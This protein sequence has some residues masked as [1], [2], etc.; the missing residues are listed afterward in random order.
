MSD[1]VSKLYA[2]IGFKV[3]QDGLKQAQTLLKELAKQMSDINN[4]TKS[5]AREFGIFS[6]SQN[7]QALNDAKLAT[8]NEKAENQRHKR[9][10][11]SKKF[12]HKQLM[13][14][15]KLEF[16]VEKYNA[17][18]K[19]QAELKKMEE[20]HAAYEKEDNKAK[21]NNKVSFGSK[22]NEL[23]PRE[24]M[25]LEAKSRLSSYTSLYS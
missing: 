3:N 7:K 12:E 22:K 25:K 15:A 10:L 14:I 23:T 13:D 9:K 18:E 17:K 20:E 11:D 21:T 6:Q 4:A 5:A 16:Q 24:K 1:A 2:E 8:E 19:E